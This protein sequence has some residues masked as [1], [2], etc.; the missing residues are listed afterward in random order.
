MNIHKFINISKYSYILI[1]DGYGLI[2]MYNTQLFLPSY[3]TTMCNK[4]KY[5]TITLN[6][7]NWKKSYNMCYKNDSYFISM[8]PKTLETLIQEISNWLLA[9]CF[10]RF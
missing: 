3:N 9:H 7:I 6:I 8:F 5:K 4:S 1:Y 10:R 2:M